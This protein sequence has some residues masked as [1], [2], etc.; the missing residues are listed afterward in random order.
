MGRTSILA[1]HDI[2]GNTAECRQ[3]VIRVISVRKKMRMCK[4]D[5]RFDSAQYSPQPSSSPWRYAS[6]KNRTILSVVFIILTTTQKATASHGKIVWTL[7]RLRTETA[8]ANVFSVFLLTHPLPSAL[9][10]LPPPPPSFTPS[11]RLPLLRL[12]M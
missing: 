10:C 9:Q 7:T 4:L 12:G 6:S 5:G 2:T 8:R 3:V 1:S 11:P